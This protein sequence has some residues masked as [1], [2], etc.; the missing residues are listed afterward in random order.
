MSGLLKVKK[1]GTTQHPQAEKVRATVT[2]ETTVRLNV[3]VPKSRRKALKARAAEE[4]R[5]IGD[6]VNELIDRY[7][8]GNLK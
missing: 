1:P 7:L 5:T 6:I 2:Q 3:D 8:S 4:D